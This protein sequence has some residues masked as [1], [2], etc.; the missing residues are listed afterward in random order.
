M[1][2]CIHTYIHTYI[3][4]CEALYTKQT[5][6]AGS[7]PPREYV[8]DTVLVTYIRG[9]FR[10]SE[11]RFYT[12]PPSRGFLSPFCC[13]RSLKSHFQEVAVYRISLPR[14]PLNFRINDDTTVRTLR[15]SACKYWGMK[16]PEQFV[17]KTMANNKCQDE[18]KV[19]ECFKQGE[20]AQLSLTKKMVENSAEPTEDEKKAIQP[21][22]GKKKKGRDG[23]FDPNGA[24]KQQ[25]FSENYFTDLKKLGGVYFLLRARDQKPSDLASKIKLR[26]IV[27]YITLTIF[28]FWVYDQRRPPGY[29]YWFIKGI[30]DK[31]VAIPGM[32][33]NYQPIPPFT[34]ITQQDEVWD[35]LTH[36]LPPQLWS[37]TPDRVLGDVVTH[38]YPSKRDLTLN[39]QNLLLGYLNIRTQGVKPQA[40]GNSATIDATL[41]ITCYPMSINEDTKES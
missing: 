11:D 40:C 19:K 37:V 26:D 21:K 3:H 29:E 30:E 17:L 14:Y 22:Q 38:G 25:N 31:T 34:N 20:L 33:D 15:E 16:T 8:L 7:K 2:A 13:S 24:D 39:G 6:S 41:G 23:G 18:V 35:W 10:Y 32:T 28:T 1:H 9:K 27:I 4:T 5:N 36:T 12:P